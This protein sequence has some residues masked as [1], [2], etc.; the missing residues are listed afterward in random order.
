MRLIPLMLAGLGLTFVLAGS[1][2]AASDQV[3]DIVFLKA[4]RCRGLAMGLAADTSGFD[5]FIKAQDRYRAPVVGQLAN[6]E[7]DKA[8]REAKNANRAAR[9]QSELADLCQAYKR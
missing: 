7:Q 4:N 1:A 2:A 6:E 3:T 8:R 5:A 9:A